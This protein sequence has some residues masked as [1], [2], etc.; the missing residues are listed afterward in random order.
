MHPNIVRFHELFEFQGSLALAMEFVDGDTLEEVIA[1]HVARARL[2]GAGTLPG[3]AVPARLAL[4][5]A[6]PRRARGDARARHR[7]PR[8]EAVEHPHPPRRHRE[9][10]RLRHRAPR[11]EPTRAAP[12]TARLAPGTGAYMSP[13]QVLVA[14]ARRAERSRTL[15]PSSSTRCSPGGRPFRSSEKSE[16]LVRME[17]V[18]TP[19]PPIRSARPQA[20][21]VL[22]AL[23]AR[24]LA[25]DPAYR[26]ASAIEMGEA[27]RRALGLPRHRSVARAG[28]DR[29]RGADEARTWRS[30][31]EDADLAADAREGV[32]APRRCGCASCRPHLPPYFVRIRSRRTSL[33][34]SRCFGSI[35][36]SAS[37]SRSASCA[38]FARLNSLPR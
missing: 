2:A 35:L 5:P 7:A 23:F 32:P 33:A 18:E 16:L 19:P 34:A 26:F 14:A 30:A 4:L 31:Q 10:H 15:Q 17:Q 6:A 13:E 11:R 22:D 8:R 38:L 28:G 21:P 27:F 20:P 36:R 24:A 37:K 25:K 12:S 3:P 1:R 29:A 9:A